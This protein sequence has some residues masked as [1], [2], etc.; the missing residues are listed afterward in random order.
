[1]RAHEMYEKANKGHSQ[2]HL[3]V[4]PERYHGR[5]F[6]RSPLKSAASTS[7]LPPATSS[8]SFLTSQSSVSSSRTQTPNA[9]KQHRS[10]TWFPVIRAQA[11]QVNPRHEAAYNKPT[12]RYDGTL[13]ST[14]S[15]SSLRHTASRQNI[16]SSPSSL[17][18]HDQDSD[19]L[20]EAQAHG[21]VLDDSA[22]IEG[23]HFKDWD[24][25]Q[26]PTTSTT[27]SSLLQPVQ[28]PPF[29]DSSSPP[30]PPRGEHS[31]VIKTGLKPL[32]PSA[33]PVN[34]NVP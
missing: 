12:N 5:E 1:M 22:V 34:P 11:P 19:W 31:V 4:S 14:P 25:E 8:K 16:R 15:L 27:A 13:P 9:G 17:M 21:V 3:M 33:L 7:E 6:D 23:R 2:R 18:A 29:T 32:L 28:D 24:E 30:S 26:Q 20:R 10:M